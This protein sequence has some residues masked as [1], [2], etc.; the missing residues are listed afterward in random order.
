MRK[1]LETEICVNIEISTWRRSN[2][3]H[4]CYC[5]AHELRIDFTFLN[6]WHKS[7]EEQYFATRESYLKSKL[8]WPFVPF[9]GNM[10]LLPGFCILSVVALVLQSQSWVAGETRCPQ[11]PKHLLCGR[12]WKMFAHPWSRGRTAQERASREIQSVMIAKLRGELISRIKNSAV[13]SKFVWKKYA[14]A[15][16]KS[17]HRQDIKNSLCVG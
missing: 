7:K 13:I 5:V 17:S 3:A 16:W 14:F 10:T 1:H 8:Q 6:C 12:L 4:H 9:R 15:L 11:S 2:L